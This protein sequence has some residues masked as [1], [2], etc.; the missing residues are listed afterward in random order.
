MSEMPVSEARDHFS[1]VV[2]RAAHGESTYLMRH[3]RRVAAVVPMSVLEELEA[4][5]DA[6]DLAAA[7]AALAED[8]PLIALEQLRSEL[9]LARLN[10]H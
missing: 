7:E 2:S 10:R 6:A 8:G 9:G 4:A 5:E 3:G 1:D